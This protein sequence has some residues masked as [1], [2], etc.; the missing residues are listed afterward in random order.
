ML[1]LYKI[2]S[3]KIKLSGILVEKK[4]LDDKVAE[5]IKICNIEYVPKGAK[6]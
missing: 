6:N 2:W 4:G 5:A 3:Q 1:D